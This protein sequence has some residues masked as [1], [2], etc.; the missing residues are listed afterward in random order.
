MTYLRKRMLEGL[1]RH[2]LDDEVE[3]LEWIIDLREFVGF[4]KYMAQVL[5]PDR[6][7]LSLV[8]VDAW[9]LTLEV[10]APVDTPTSLILSMSHLGRPNGT[11]KG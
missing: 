1:Q 9:R 3:S 10:C 5:E 6:P 8:D 2:V 4:R 7:F 11:I